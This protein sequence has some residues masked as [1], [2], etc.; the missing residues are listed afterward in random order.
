MS[1]PNSGPEQRKYK[2]PAQMRKK[3]TAYFAKKEG[4]DPS[5]EPSTQAPIH[6]TGMCLYLDIT[7]QTLNNY[8]KIEGYEKVIRMAKL[9]CEA[10]LV[11]Q[12]IVGKPGNKSDFVLSNNFGW[13]HKNHQDT[14]ISG[15][16]RHATVDVA[17]LTD[18]EIHVELSQRTM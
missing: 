13:K 17:S 12:A 6:I 4:P 9:R 7:N 14:T 18:E 2:S 11:D 3:M 10:Y 5:G 1:R 8:E 16:L 15:T